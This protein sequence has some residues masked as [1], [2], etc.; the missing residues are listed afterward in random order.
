MTREEKFA[1]ALEIIKNTRG[2]YILE[3]QDKIFHYVSFIYRGYRI[4]VQMNKEAIDEN[5]PG[6]VIFDIFKILPDGCQQ[7]Q[8]TYF[9]NF[10]DMSS[11]DAIIDDKKFECKSD[12]RPLMAGVISKITA[13][14][15]LKVIDKNG[16]IR[17]QGIWA[18]PHF[19]AVGGTWNGDHKI[20][21]VLRAYPEEDGYFD[22]FQVDLMTENICG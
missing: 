14:K 19:C 20:V 1:R 11:I 15:L 21:D 13:E 22:G 4:Y 6:E 16:S 3:E 10:E 2:I 7:T 8:I 17:E 12:V 5:H 9:E 18:S